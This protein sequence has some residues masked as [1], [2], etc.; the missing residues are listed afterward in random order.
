[1]ITSRQAV[2]A[3]AATYD[4]GAPTFRQFGDAVS[5][6][7][8]TIDGVKAVAIEGTH[9]SF[10]W[11]LDF[12]A[13]PTAAKETVAHP[14]LPP[15]HR[16]F[17]DAA[18]S[19]LP[20]VRAAIKGKPWCAIGHSLGGA[21]ALTL[22]AWLAD[23]GTPPQ[24]VYLFAPARVFVDAPD[25][26]ADVPIEGWRCGGDIVPMVPPWCWRPI[27]THFAGPMDESAHGIANFLGFIK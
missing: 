24:S 11:A 12:D 4:G 25:V 20:A 19:V 13:W 21:V 23:E 27:L 22:G 2:E 16:G 5:V 10:G 14:T 18:V 8:T 6:F 1:M 26:L 3:A 17:R 15:M 7:V 9:D